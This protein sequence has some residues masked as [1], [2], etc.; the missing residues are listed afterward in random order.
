MGSVVSI[1]DRLV[2]FRNQ[3][4]IA[5]HK[6]LTE[7]ELRAKKDRIRSAASKARRRQRQP[8]W[9]D[10]KKI[11]WFYLEADRL[12]KKT[13]KAY[14]VDH[15]IPLNGKYVSGLHVENNLQILRKVENRKKSN[16][17]AE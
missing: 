13:G 12:R 4:Q 6:K 1:L 7:K 17:Y 10:Q 3:E 8:P 5:V 2:V 16:T 9:A 15:I 11:E 14:E